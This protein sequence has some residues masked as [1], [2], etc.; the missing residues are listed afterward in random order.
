M[1][2]YVTTTTVHACGTIVVMLAKS[3]ARCLD[4]VM[5]T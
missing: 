5:E 4:V 1:L 2:G 3:P